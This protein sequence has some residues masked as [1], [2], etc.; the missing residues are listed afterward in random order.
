MEIWFKIVVVGLGIVAIALAFFF[1][2]AMSRK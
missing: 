2:L 1:C